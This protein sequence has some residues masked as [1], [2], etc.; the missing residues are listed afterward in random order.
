MGGLRPVELAV[1]TGR[2]VGWWSWCV[3]GPAGFAGRMRE[4]S[5]LRVA[6]GGDTRLLLVSGDAGVGKTRFVREGLW[7][8]APEGLVAVWGACMPLA[9]RLPLLPVAAALGALGRVDGGGLLEAALGAAP[10]YVRGEAGRL[11]PQLGPAPAAAGDRDEGWRRERLFSGLAELLWAAAR[12]SALAL[13][14]DD[15]QWADSESLDFLTLLTRAVRADPVT[16]VAAC[17]SDEAPLDAHVAGWLAQVRGAAGVEEI[18]LGPLSRGEVAAQVAWLA[19]G[20][21]PARVVE[22]VYARAEGN[23]FYTEQLVAA[24]PRTGRGH[25]GPAGGPADPAGGA[26]GGPGGRLCR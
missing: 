18:R 2:G 26:A 5:R 1:L 12:Q 19:G 21:A 16:V 11:L 22:M 24:A 7:Q 10:E 14:I 23:P 3:A 15:V 8:A 13:V 9:G 17:R 4:L 20:L 25:A 6:L